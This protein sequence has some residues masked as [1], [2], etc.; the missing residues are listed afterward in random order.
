MKAKAVRLLLLAAVCSVALW[1]P[2]VSHAWDYCPG[3]SCPFWREVCEGNT[4]TFTQTN[5]GYCI[6]DDESTTVLWF[7]ECTYTWRGPWTMYCTG[8]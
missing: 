1:P 2:A 6:Q 5:I 8:I 3:Q 7:A 4:G